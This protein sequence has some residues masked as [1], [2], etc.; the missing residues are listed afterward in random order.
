VVVYPFGDVWVDGKAFGHAPVSLKLASGT[1][2]IG[3]GDGRPEQRRSVQ[4][5]SGQHEDLVFR[6]A[7]E[8]H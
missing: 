1:H 3:V 7:V 2:E 5:H 4:V 8:V 6:R